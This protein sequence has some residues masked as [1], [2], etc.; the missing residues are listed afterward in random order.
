MLF[1]SL[2]ASSLLAMA[3]L[4]V[5][6]TLV[7]LQLPLLIFLTASFCMVEEVRATQGQ[8]EFDYFKLALQ[9][10][11]TY[12]QSTRQCCSSNACCRGYFSFDQLIFLFYSS[13]VYLV[14]SNSN[15]A[16]LFS[17][18]SLIWFPLSDR[19]IMR[20]KAFFFF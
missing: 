11:G 14:V 7:H 16:M 6:S 10:P 20:R 2:L 13:V 1:L 5:K 15:L 12:C 4:S 18:I 3:S 8:R 17:C 9:W 19:V